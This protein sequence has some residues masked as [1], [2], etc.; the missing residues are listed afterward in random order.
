M[1][2]SRCCVWG[3]LR[4]DEAGGGRSCWDRGGTRGGC[5]KSPA[6]HGGTP[7]M[8]RL[9]ARC[10]IPSRGL[11]ARQPPRET[12]PVWG[13]SQN[14]PFPSPF[15]SIGFCGGW[16]HPPLC[17]PSTTSRGCAGPRRL[18]VLREPNSSPGSRSEPAWGMRDGG[19]GGG[20]EGGDG[21][22]TDRRDGAKGRADPSHGEGRRS[23][24]SPD[25]RAGEGDRGGV[26]TEWGWGHSG[27]GD[28]AGVGT[29]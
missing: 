12:P 25:G 17:S 2:G 7:G 13:A 22:R 4:Q 8:C 18:F 27:G 11:S 1:G 6:S 10:R 29:H 15:A 16:C 9:C 19:G 14:P 21:D 20:E 23:A 5:R 24:L 28:R 3:K 26:G